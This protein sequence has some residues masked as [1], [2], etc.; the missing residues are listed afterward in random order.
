MGEWKGDRA[1]IN[2]KGR[3]LKGDTLTEVLEATIDKQELANQLNKLILAGDITAIKYAYDRIDGT[4]KQTIDNHVFQDDLH[5][6]AEEL[7]ELR[8]AYDKNVK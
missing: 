7:R 1:N 4:A 2:R 3:P 8:K 5:P 6:V